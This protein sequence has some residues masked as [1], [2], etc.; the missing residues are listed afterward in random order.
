M[1]DFVEQR[2]GSFYL[3]GSRVPLATII[4]DFQNGEAPEAI[5]SNFPTLSLPQVDGGI[6]FYLGNK[7]EVEKDMAERRCV[8]DEFM[9]THPVSPGLKQKLVYARDQRLSRRN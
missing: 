5:Q 7:D 6:T 8:E 9:K 2:D 4:H 1:Q 3:V